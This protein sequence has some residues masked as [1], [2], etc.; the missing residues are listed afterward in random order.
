MATGT[1]STPFKE[2][3]ITASWHEDGARHYFGEALQPPSFAD[4]RALGTANDPGSSPLA[5][6]ADHTHGPG[7]TRVVGDVK[8]S[9][10]NSMPGWVKLDGT[11]YPN[12]NI[13]FPLLWAVV[14]ASWK[15]GN[16]LNVP[17]M[18]NKVFHPSLNIN[19]FI[20]VGA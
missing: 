5:A 4:T 6:R 10:V 19:F 3:P 15:T 7:T 18:S 16:T 14:A 17:D 1:G 2:S 9:A 20:Y 8:A 12:G 11:N 13:Q